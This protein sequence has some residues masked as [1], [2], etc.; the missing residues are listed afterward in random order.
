MQQWI[1]DHTQEDE[2]GQEE[3]RPLGFDTLA[4]PFF[5]LIFFGW[6]ATLTCAMEWATSLVQKQS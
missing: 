6:L 5:A 1:P 3:V 2:F 4:F